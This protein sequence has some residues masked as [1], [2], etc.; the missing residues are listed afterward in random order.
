MKWQYKAMVQNAIARL[1]MSD[2]IY[3]AVQRTFGDLR[4]SR[5]DPM[6]WIS[7]ACEMVLWLKS[8]GYRIAGK[9]FLEVGTGRALGMPLTLWLCGAG[10][11]VTVD[12]N[13]YLSTGLV[14][15][16][17]R[18]LRRNQ[19][20]IREFLQRA[21]DDGDSQKRLDQLLAF[22]GNIGSFLDLIHVQY[23]APADA[24]KLP[25]PDHS[26]DFHFSYAVLEHVPGPIILQILREAKRILRPTGAVLHS[27]DLSDHFWYS[28]N[29]IQ[30]INCL[31]FSQE[32]WRRWA[33]NKY[34]YHNRLR[35]R[36][37]LELFA[38]AGVRIGH[39]SRTLH[40][41]SL[42]AVKNG[43]PLDPQFRSVP[44]EELAVTSLRIMGSFPAEPQGEGARNQHPV[45]WV[46]IP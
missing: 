13:R 9:Q 35:V 19:A 29:S 46:H 7:A 36:E 33:G 2:P 31:R 40:E 8:A 41:G 42:V 43:F 6:E 21:D 4:P 20:K 37:L 11:T 10:G 44:V 45:E 17:N 1:P 32:E 3:Y 23:L 28:D 34:M 27:I 5:F 14:M 12:L 24:G 39:E 15:D 22:S 18:Y 25:F 26:F 30:R 38:E 16:C